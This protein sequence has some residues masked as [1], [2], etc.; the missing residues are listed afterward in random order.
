MI[1]QVKWKLGGMQ[2]WLFWQISRFNLKTV[3]YT[4]IVTMEDEYKLVCDLSN[5][6]ISNGFEWSLT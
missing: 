3:Q 4:A 1:V 5:G 6:V 2:N